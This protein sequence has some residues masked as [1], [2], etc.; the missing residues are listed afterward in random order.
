MRSY[1]KEHL[2]Q[3]VRNLFAQARYEFK[4]V[5][6]LEDKFNAAS[7]KGMTECKVFSSWENDMDCFYATGFKVWK[8]NGSKIMIDLYV[9][10]KYSEYTCSCVMGSSDTPEGVFEWLRDPDS[11]AK[12]LAKVEKLVD[13]IE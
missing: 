2:Q 4:V 7:G 9:Y 6:N 8:F 11:L 1:N 5:L 13:D 3:C 12:C 10:V